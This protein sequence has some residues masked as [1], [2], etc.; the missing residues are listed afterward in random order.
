MATATKKGRVSGPAARGA[1]RASNSH[2]PHACCPD[3][4]LRFAP[5]EAAYLIVCPECGEPLQA[6]SELAGAV[7][8]RLFTVEDTPNS[9]PDALAV[10]MPLPDPG[11][12]RS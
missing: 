4:R 12:R 2:G 5:A 8:F 3:C 10:S 1:K 7:G 11:T 9:L 6:L